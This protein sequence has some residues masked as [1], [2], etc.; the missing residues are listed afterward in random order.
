MA[1]KKRYED[2][3]K[4]VS[5]AKNKNVK[6]RVSH[7]QKPFKLALR[8]V[9]RSIIYTKRKVN[10]KTKW[11]ILE[12]AEDITFE[13]YSEAI[14]SDIL[15]LFGKNVQYFIPVYS[16]EINGNVV[17]DILFDGYFFIK[18]SDDFINKI[19]NIKSD[20]IKGVMKK[21]SKIIEINGSKINEFKKEMY[22]KLLSLAPKR[23]QL[24]SPKIGI[25]SNLKGEV[26]SV[27]KRN[28]TFLARFKCSSRIV[29]APVN[30][31]NYKCVSP[32]EV[33]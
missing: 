16:E 6:N 15:Q 7:K 11:A 4:K 25:L 10:S 30:F 9:D 19:D 33:I 23:K 22:D 20:N 1:I 21:N 8:D 31:I 18:I 28:M 29:E 17:S 13:D 27:N 26:L 5:K 24:I 2:K 32:D 3:N 14:E 12:L